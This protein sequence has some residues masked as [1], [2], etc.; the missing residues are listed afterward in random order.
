M[1]NLHLYK[2]SVSE[3]SLTVNTDGEE[4]NYNAA[5]VP[6]LNEYEDNS[7][8]LQLSILH[9]FWFFFSKLDNPAHFN[10][11]ISDSS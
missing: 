3:L 5:I 11:C 7:N 10:C 6:T 8:V 2:A 4:Q 1:A 9:I